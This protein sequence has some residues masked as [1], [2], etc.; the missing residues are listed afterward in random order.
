M[1]GAVAVGVLADAPDQAAAQAQTSGQPVLPRPFRAQAPGFPDP[2]LAIGRP[3]MP[4]TIAQLER[5]LNARRA[6]AERRAAAARSTIEGML[7]TARAQGRANFSRAESARID[8]LLDERGRA[9]AELDAVDAELAEC[10]D[11]AAD[12]IRIADGQRISRSSGAPRPM[13][14]RQHASVSI[15]R[16]ARTYRPDEDPHGVQF[17]RDVAANFL[18]A[19]PGASSRLGQHMAEE[20]VERGAYLHRAAGDTTTGNFAGLT[21]P[22]YLTDMYAKAI[23]NLRP[24][25]DNSTHHDLPPSGMTINI[26]QITTPTLVNNPATE[27]PAA[28]ATQT[29]DDTLLTE[30]VLTA[31]GSVLLSR[32]AIDRGTGIEEAT[33][34]DLFRRY[35]TN[36][37]STMI[38]QAVT[39]ISAIAQ[40]TTYT[41][42]SPTPQLL[43]PNLFKA[44][45]L[46]EQA[47]EGVA[48]PNFLVMHSRRWNWFTSTLGSTWPLIGGSN[49]AAQSGGVVMSNEY[50]SGVRG[51]LPNGMKV[52]VDNNIPTN[53][54]A[55]TN[56]DEIYIVANEEVH[57]WEDP[58]AP[59]LI[60]AEQPQATRLG[61]LLVIYGYY[62]Y[63]VRRY[64]NGVGKI[65]GTGLVAPAGF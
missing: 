32:Q 34:L 6:A 30:N 59:V 1:P 62:A 28:V 2:A 58:N 48:I 64:A 22:Q 5:Q 51:V 61:V 9:T 54:G 10:H 47:L 15:G 18:H 44:Q 33:T 31:A 36:L 56:Q 25:A 14:N 17:L 43:W 46:L 19:D 45:S 40:T 65:S 60:R 42:A 11:A 4:I 29:I 24:L 27:L 20:R 13:S 12:E 21:V 39:G 38:N 7:A 41:D 37:D 8:A 50:G 52:I 16:E 23:A 53:L 35:A 63:T 3:V 49:T 26:S 55:G 57:L